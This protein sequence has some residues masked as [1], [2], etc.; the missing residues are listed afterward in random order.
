MKSTEQGAEAMKVRTHL[1]AGGVN[2]QHNEALRVRTAIKAGGLNQNHHEALRVRT[3]IKVGGQDLN[4]NEAL[5]VRSAVKVGGYTQNHNEALRREVNRP[6]IS[7]RRQPRTTVRK[8][9]RLGL[10]VV[11][12]GVRAGARAR[13]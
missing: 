12:A 2:M 5:R 10:L 7:M 9:D 11:R 6:A 13:R 3:S 4:H 8:E 1:K